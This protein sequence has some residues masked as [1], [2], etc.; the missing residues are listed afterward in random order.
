MKTRLSIIGLVAVALVVGLFL[1]TGRAGAT[2]PISWYPELFDIAVPP[3]GRLPTK[4]T[5]TITKSLPSTRVEITPS[6]AQHLVSVEPTTFP[7]LPTGSTVTIN[8]IFGVAT[9]TPHRLIRGTLHLKETGGKGKGTQAQPLPIALTIGDLLYPPDPGEAGKAALEGIDSDGDGLR[10]D[11]QRY[12]EL[13]HPNEPA[14]RAGLRQYIFPLQ[15]A[16][17]DADSGETAL[18]HTANLDRAD[19]CLQSLIG[20]RPTIEATDKLVAEF[21]NTEERSRAYIL[22]DSQL[23]G[24][25]FRLRGLSEINTSLCDFDPITIGGER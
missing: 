3:G 15:R 20:L 8:L 6:L 4:I 2:P 10:D 9:G 16:L 21:L 24:H 25:V 13:T 12:I 17:V 1:H 7:A 19:D 11:I 18:Q 5:A 14:T 23:G 22:Y